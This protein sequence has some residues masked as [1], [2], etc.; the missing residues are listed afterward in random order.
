M[1]PKELFLRLRV[2]LERLRRFSKGHNRDNAP[3]WP[4]ERLSRNIVR[5]DKLRRFAKEDNRD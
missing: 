2:R 1:F 4:I 5:F 3:M